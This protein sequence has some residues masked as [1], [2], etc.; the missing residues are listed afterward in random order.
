MSLA[1]GWLRPA[2]LSTPHSQEGSQKSWCCEL[3]SFSK[4]CPENRRGSVVKGE[5]GT[6]EEL[7][8][9][10]HLQE[11]HSRFLPGGPHPLT[12]ISD[13]VIPF[14]RNTGETWGLPS[15]PMAM[16]TRRICTHQASLLGRVALVSLNTG[17]WSIG[18]KFGMTGGDESVHSHHLIPRCL[19]GLVHHLV[20]AT[21]QP[22]ERKYW[23][24]ISPPFKQKKN[25][26][27]NK[28]LYSSENIP[29]NPLTANWLQI[30]ANYSCH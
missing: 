7:S 15:A 21:K 4:S 23:V 8:W 6:W 22:V 29:E 30:L 9:L 14:T 28:M 11:R 1:A 3:G 5:E 18:R 27:K 13:Y 16:R 10:C 25:A 12:T 26:V 2:S 20:C 17:A 24:S 19:E